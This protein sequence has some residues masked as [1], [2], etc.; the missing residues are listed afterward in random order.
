MRDPLWAVLTHPDK[1]KGGWDPQEFFLTGVSEIDSVLRYLDSIHP[2]VN[3]ECALDFGCGVGRITQ[4]LAPHFGR[5]IGL[6]VAPSMIERARAYN[7]H[8]S[9]CEY[10]LNDQ[11]DLRIL[12]DRRFDFIYSNMTLQHMPLHLGK[13]Y[14]AE[15]LRVLASGGLLLFQLPSR[16]RK[17]QSTVYERLI[18][19]LYYDVFRNFLRPL[20]PYME[21]HGAGKE[22]VVQFLEDHGGR[23]LD[24]TADDYAQPH[25]E[26]FRYLATRRT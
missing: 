14:I 6:D 24:V 23:V 5:V 16:V 15:F 18:R 25:W 17:D 8:G 20:T 26:G 9:R 10:L 7:R 13:S 1:K 11:P 21:M 22:E 2:L 4:A 19:K 12:A 3:R